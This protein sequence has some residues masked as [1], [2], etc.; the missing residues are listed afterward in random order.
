MLKRRKVVYKQ[1]LA[2]GKSLLPLYTAN[3]EFDYLAKV[4]RFSDKKVCSFTYYLQTTIPNNT[5]TPQK[6]KEKV[7]SQ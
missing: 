7:L 4:E 1:H 5:Q 3:P 2:T 6:E